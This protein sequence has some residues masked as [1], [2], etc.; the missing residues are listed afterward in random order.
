MTESAR[1]MTGTK[2]ESDWYFYHDALNLMTAKETRRWMEGREINGS[3]CAKKW[4]V[5]INGCNGGTKYE[6][7]MVG[8]SP[9]FM[10]MDMSLNWDVK[11]SHNFHC[12]ITSDLDEEDER[13]FS[14][15]TPKMI[16]RGIK[17]LFEYHLP[18]EGVPCSSRI[19]HDCDQ[20][21]RA[22]KIV[23]DHRGAIIPGLA[24]RNSHRYTSDGT[25]RQG[26]I[27]EK[28]YVL[29][30][31]RWLHPIVST[32]RDEKQANILAKFESLHDSEVEDVM[33]SDANSVATENSD[34]DSSLTENF[35]AE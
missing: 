29:A 28:C 6:N 32:L 27:R 31:G 4:L 5:P 23:C 22:M 35:G 13:K 11:S 16:A 34:N 7:R 25:N 9:E 26:G 10:P 14:M 15:K 24:N 21:L 30:E 18:A 3:N 1:V 20:A 17:R 12:A 19:I 2:H 33:F 8:N